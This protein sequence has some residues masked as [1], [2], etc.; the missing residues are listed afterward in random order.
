MK[1]IGNSN[2]F[3]YTENLTSYMASCMRMLFE[4][5]TALGRPVVPE[6]FKIATV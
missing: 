1:E 5:Q 4:M 3:F 2:P 6:E